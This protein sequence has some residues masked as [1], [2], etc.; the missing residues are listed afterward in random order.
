MISYFPH[1]GVGGIGGI[2][3]VINY[4]N[5][6]DESEDHSTSLIEI[7]ELEAAGNAAG[8]LLCIYSFEWLSY[9]F[10]QIFLFIILYNI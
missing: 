8:N 4:R 5:C 9:Y 7:Q 1:G 2:G 6:C 3:G 10:S